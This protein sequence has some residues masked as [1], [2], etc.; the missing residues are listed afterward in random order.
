MDKNVNISEEP[1]NLKDVSYANIE[2]ERLSDTK[3]AIS[4]DKDSYA[5]LDTFGEDTP[6]I[7]NSLVWEILENNF[8]TDFIPVNAV[9]EFLMAEEVEDE[10][11]NLLDSHEEPYYPKYNHV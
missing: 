8:D 1:D 6:F 9:H 5:E 11:L 10:L 7:N 3:Y 4:D 2:V